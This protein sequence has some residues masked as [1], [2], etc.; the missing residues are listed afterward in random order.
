MAGRYSAVVSGRSGSGSG[1]VATLRDE[2]SGASAR[3]LV[4]YGFNLFDLRLPA[5]GEVRRILESAEDFAERPSNPARNGT[6]ILFPY[7]NRVAGG[8]YAF[9]GREYRLPVTLGPNAIHGFA[10]DAAWDAAAGV[11][12]GAG[13]KVSGRYQISKNSPEA[14]GMWPTDAVMEVTYTLSGRTL[15]M[16]VE[17][18]NPTA[19]ELPYGFGIHPYF[20]LPMDPGGDNRRTRV[21]LPATKRWV[22]EE[23]LPTGE[24]RA[25]TAEE[26]FRGAGRPMAGLKQDDVYTGL[27]LDAESGE[28]VCRLVDEAVGAEFRLSFDKSFRELVVYTP[29]ADGRVISLEPY[30]QTTDAINLQARGVDA[31]LRVLG[32][33]ER[34][35]LR[36][37]FSTVDV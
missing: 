18:L 16:D 19:R 5:G 36:I 25:L 27:E 1:R 3:V 35:S 9:G 11:E 7:P 30:T 34:D 10:M 37:R 20:R 31:G 4:D 24:V 17:I 21:I 32:H 13:A 23:F 15:T 22:L 2:A 8:K 33:G 26:D 12:E 28:Y 6:P 14:A 29:V